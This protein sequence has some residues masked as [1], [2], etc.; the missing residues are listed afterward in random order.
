MTP[1]GSRSPFDPL[2]HLTAVHSSSPGAPSRR[3]PA[4]RTHRRLVRLG[5]MLLICGPALALAHLISDAQSTDVAWW[6]YTIASFDIAVI[7]VI[8]ALALILRAP[9]GHAAE[10]E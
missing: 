9:P 1:T 2:H 6:T 3:S 7:M 5:Y 10:T 8:V 4:E